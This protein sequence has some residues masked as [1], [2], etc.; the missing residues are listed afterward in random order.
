MGPIHFRKYL[1]T[2]LSQNFQILTKVLP[3]SVELW[4]KNG[5]EMGGGGQWGQKLLLF[6]LVFMGVVVLYDVFDCVLVLYSVSKGVFVL[7]S[8]LKGVLVL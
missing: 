8:V 4:S 5:S 1:I 3:G 6:I 7:Y 2:F